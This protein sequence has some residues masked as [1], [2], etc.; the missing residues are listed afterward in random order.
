MS[1]WDILFLC[2]LSYRTPSYD[3]ASD[4][5]ILYYSAYDW[6]PNPTETEYATLVSFDENG[7]RIQCIHRYV[8]PDNMVN[9]MSELLPNSDEGTLLYSDDKVYYLDL[10]T[11]D[12]NYAGFYY[13]DTKDEYMNNTIESELINLPGHGWNDSTAVFISKQ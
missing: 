10:D 9:T 13:F 12:E 4:D 7:R 6:E 8:R 3:S 11:A 2:C 5:Y 1:R